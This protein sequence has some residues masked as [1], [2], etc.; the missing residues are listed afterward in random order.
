MAGE[1]A[2]LPSI[3]AKVNILNSVDLWADA[4][5]VSAGLSLVT[6][7]TFALEYCA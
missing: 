7:V 3:A 2:K 4:P 1:Q 6:L 5:K